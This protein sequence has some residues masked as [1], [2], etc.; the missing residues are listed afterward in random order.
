VQHG[1]M[2]NH[3]PLAFFLFSIFILWFLGGAEDMPSGARGIGAFAFEVLKERGVAAANILK[4][5]TLR[6]GRSAQLVEVEGQGV[7]PLTKI[8]TPTWRSLPPAGHAKMWT[9]GGIRN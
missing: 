9:V 4:V 2:G 7:L 5:R 3:R 8:F 6:P 1:A